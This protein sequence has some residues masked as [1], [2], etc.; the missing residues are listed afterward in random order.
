MELP[1]AAPVPIID[2][3][4]Q[5]TLGGTVEVPMP[6]EALRDQHS[7][8]NWPSTDITGHL[9]KR[10][11]ER[12]ERDQ[13]VGDLDLWLQNLDRHH[14]E[15]AQVPLNFNTPFEVFDQLSEHAD[16]VFISLR[17]NPHDGMIAVRKMNEVH[18]RY[19]FLRS[20]AIAPHQVYP[21]AGPN[22]KEY[23]PIYAKC[24]ELDLAVM[25]NVGFPGP[26]VPAY[27]Q[28][29]LLLDEVCWFFPDLRVVMKHG[30][31]PWADTCV[32]MLERWPNLFYMT[33]G[34]APK[35][36]PKPVLNFVNRRGRDKLIYAGYWPLLSYERIFAELSQLD[37]RDEVWPRFLNGNATT[38][39]GLAQVAQVAHVAETELVADGGRPR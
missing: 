36:Y 27:T 6:R 1:E 9:F 10:D 12:A 8:D 23:Y 25:I 31:E 16:R 22:S 15:R 11:A 4:V 18:R 34:F 20:V 35:F 21:Q 30:G 3:F 2:S 29:P 13:I 28:D 19:P 7:L 5:L 37:L 38:A 39:F 17:L 14:I 32:K 26:R 33:T 24:V